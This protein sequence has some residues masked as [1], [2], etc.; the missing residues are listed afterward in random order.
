MHKY[1]FWLELTFFLFF[2]S[3]KKICRESQSLVPDRRKLAVQWAAAQINQTIVD[4]VEDTYPIVGVLLA[5]ND[6]PNDEASAAL[7]DELNG[8]LNLSPSQLFALNQVGCV[9]FPS[10][11][12]LCGGEG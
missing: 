5:I 6:S 1:L 2:I 4:L 9:L 10:F 3:I 12:F 7:R 8:V 11:F